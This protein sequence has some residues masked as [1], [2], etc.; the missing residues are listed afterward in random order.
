MNNRIPA[1]MAYVPPAL[2]KRQ[3]GDAKGDQV[4]NDRSPRYPKQD[5]TS[6]LPTVYDIQNHFWPTPVV[7]KDTEKQVGNRE[8]GSNSAQTSEDSSKTTGQTD[9]TRSNTQDADLASTTSTTYPLVHQHSTLNATE[10]EPDKLRYVLLFRDAHPRWKADMIIYAKSELHILPR[11]TEK[12]SSDTTTSTESE[13]PH[14]KSLEQAPPDSASPP[15]EP[16]TT[17]IAFFAEDN[18]SPR[19]YSRAGFK[20]IGYF[21][22][23]HMQIL[24]PNTPDLAR[25]LEQ[26]WTR[27]NS[28]GKA[29]QVQ[30]D[31]E[32]WKKSLGYAWAVLKFEKDEKVTAE[33]GEPN[34]KV[35]D[36]VPSSK[37]K[38]IV[39]RASRKSVNEMLMDM[40]LKDDKPAT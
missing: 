2:R 14:S 24:R 22:L 10:A 21:N 38:E 8:D 20:F 19:S 15:T 23:I 18:N 35:L 16:L 26:K 32:A 5:S 34:I 33:L 31:P 36:K 6:N 11:T 3:Q 25:M 17:R 28:W 13:A 7:Q 40:R 29:R 37:E 30:R 9:E 27:T 39:P 12:N 1:R 4:E